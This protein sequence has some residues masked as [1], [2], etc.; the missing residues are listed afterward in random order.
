MPSDNKTNLKVLLIN[1]PPFQIIEP[2]YDTPDYPRTALAFLAGYLRDKN[3]AVAVVDCKF[4]RLDY[5]QALEKI[6]NFEPDIVGLTAFTNEIKQ[7]AHVARLI[8]EY[9]TQIKT[10]IG[11][12]HITALPEETLREFSE[13]DFGVVGEGEEALYELCC[14]LKTNHPITAKSICCLDSLGAYKFYGKRPPLVDQDALKPAWD[15]FRPAKEYILHTSRG[16]PYACIFC[17]NPNGRIVRPRSVE[18]TLNE[19]EWLVENMKPKSILFGD[20]I[21]TIKRDRT[22]EICR[23]LIKRGIHKKISWWCQTH[24]NTIDE[25]LV[26]LMKAS[27]C[28]VVGLGVETGDEEKLKKMGKGISV[29]KIMN[30]V[31]IMKKANLAFKA[32]FILGQPNETYESAKET[33]NFA[34]KINPTMPIFGIMVPYP[35]TKIAEMVEK[36]E[37][38]YTLITNDWNDYN[39]QFGNAVSLKSVTR[40]QLERLQFTG[41]LKVFIYNFR[42]IDL[43]EFIFQYRNEGFAALKK[44]MLLSIET[45]KSKFKK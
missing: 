14:Q 18:T 30:A 20:E 4:D 36:G 29:S 8:K 3:I 24:V 27:N 40:S 28:S 1:P 22:A 42:F 10:V 19:I 15:M 39:K 17:M 11:G 45:I 41:Y 37:G 5:D 44:Q 25:E 9:D 2:Y 33:I 34:V 23:G 7:A 32:F 43:L 35:G 16:C 31:K 38:G 21:F 13:F 26:K 12:V 6:K